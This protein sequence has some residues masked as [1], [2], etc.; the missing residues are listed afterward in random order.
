MP[1]QNMLFWYTD[2]SE[3]K[4]LEIQQMKE[5]GFSELLLSA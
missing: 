1:S 3:L 5:E 2:Y 4:A